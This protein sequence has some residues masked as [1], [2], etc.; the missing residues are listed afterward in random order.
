MQGIAIA[1]L[2]SLALRCWV[3]VDAS[4]DS[5]NYHLPFAAKLWGIA[6]DQSYLLEELMQ[7]RF[8]GFPLLANWF[9]GLLWKITGRVEAANLVN[10]VAFLS[11]LVFSQF[12]LKVPFHTMA[13]ALLAIPMLQIQITTSYVDPFG[14]LFASIALLSTYLAYKNNTAL[15]QKQIL[16]F[17]LSAFFTVNTKLQ[18]AP[19]I[20][21]TLALFGGRFA[22]LKYREQ[23]GQKVTWVRILL[24]STVSALLI[25][26]VPVRNTIVYGN[27]AYPVK[28]TIAGHTLNHEEVTPYE[29]PLYLKNAPQFQRWIYSVLEINASDPRRPF[30]WT[31]GQGDVPLDSKGWVMGGYFGI[32]VVFNSI[33]FG[34]LIKLLP[35]KQRFLPVAFLLILCMGTSILPQSHV[36]R[37]YEYW[38]I[39]FVSLN[40][41]LIKQ[42][43]T[44]VGRKLTYYL[45]HKGLIFLGFLVMVT[46]LTKATYIVPHFYSMDDRKKDAIDRSILEKVEARS[47]SCLVGLQ[48]NTFIYSSVFQ[49]GSYQLEA[50]TQEKECMAPII[51]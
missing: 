19:V 51:K 3:D 49:G 39:C 24:A 50:A 46:A 9:Q 44:L 27:P 40:L 28:L 42:V 31:N 12:C 2:A 29:V 8:E 34:L 21:L 41:I 18:L 10:Y 32:Y 26:A 7:Q 16:I 48:P 33:L 11:Y 13:V 15:T 35:K 23:P 47:S 36:L 14:N 6:T 20:L 37:F 43:S 45:L 17:L 5:W 30:L 1:L 25:F 38:M 4:W 22:F